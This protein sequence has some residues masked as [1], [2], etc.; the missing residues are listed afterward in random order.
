[1]KILLG[2]IAGIILLT[3]SIYFYK[4]IIGKPGDF[5][6]SLLEALET[7]LMEK[8]SAAQPQMWLLIFISAVIEIIYFAM[9]FTLLTH[10]LMRFLT[11][12]MVGEELYHLVIVSIR[13]KQFF[14]QQIEV[15]G[16]FNWSM[17]RISAV[18]FFTYS[19]LVLT[20][21]VIFQC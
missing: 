16:I 14:K 4:I 7:W 6:V 18:M 11:A 19:F 8:G 9:T 21:L 2:I 15:S 13:F 10:P 17:E 1:M 5:E 3:Y 12:F 20:S